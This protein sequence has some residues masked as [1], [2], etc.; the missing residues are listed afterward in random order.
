MHQISAA[1]A[2]APKHPS[3]PG[4]GGVLSVCYPHPCAETF[5]ARR[6]DGLQRAL[7]AAGSGGG[8]RPYVLIEN[9]SK[10]NTNASGDKVLPNGAVW[11]SALVQKVRSWSWFG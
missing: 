4:S 10:C 1:Q 9:S 3:I 11:L 5:L 6:L 2:A 7:Q 8:P